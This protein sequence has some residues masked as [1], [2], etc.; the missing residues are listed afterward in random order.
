MHI[1]PARSRAKL[2]H[3]RDPRLW[4]INPIFSSYPACLAVRA[5]CEQGPEAGLRYLRRLREGIFCERRKLDHADA[6]LADAG[7]AGRASA[8]S[9]DRA[10]RRAGARSPG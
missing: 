1:V 2:T 10:G 5:A 6:L 9:G 4:T 8:R 3:Y 7:S